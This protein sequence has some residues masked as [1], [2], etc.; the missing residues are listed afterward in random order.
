MEKIKM[1]LSDGRALIREGMCFSL[2]NETDFVITGKYATNAEALASILSNPPDLAILSVNDAKLDGIEAARQIKQRL[3]SVTVILTTESNDQKQPSVTQNS[4]ADA[5]ISKDINPDDLIEVARKAVQRKRLSAID[6]VKLQVTSKIPVE[7]QKTIPAAQMDE[8]SGELRRRFAEIRAK[9]YGQHNEEENPK[10]QHKVSKEVSKTTTKGLHPLPPQKKIRHEVKKDATTS[11]KSQPKSPAKLFD[12][13]ISGVLCLVVLALAL[14]YFLPG[15]DVFIVRSESMV[16]NIKM[17][18][19]IITGPP[20]NFINGQ[21]EPGK[22]ITYQH[23]KGL[24]THRVVS[25]N[26]EILVTRGDNCEEPDP[27]KVTMSDVRGLILLRIP[28][29][30]FI[31]NFMRTKLG[32][33]L[34][35]MLPGMLLVALLVKEI[36]KEALKNDENK[37]PKKRKLVPVNYKAINEKS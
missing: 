10:V 1:V 37:S 16:P 11:Q 2:S 15:Y 24:V 36:I 34:V 13:I 3:Q 22:V 6:I 14:I 31:T 20:G 29:I 8:R 5:C 28:Y 25:V 27:W 35:I 18:D 19:I 30:G 12:W 4:A 17:G 7:S 32:W 33:F 23:G 26:G 21:V 9:R